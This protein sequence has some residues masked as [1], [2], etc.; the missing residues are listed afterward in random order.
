M[1]LREPTNI[2]R[3][4]A[5]LAP[6]VRCFATGKAWRNKSKVHSA[7]Y[8]SGVTSGFFALIQNVLDAIG[9]LKKL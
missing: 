3:D 8:I 6:L 7:N 4:Q 2:T 1:A 5:I 9:D